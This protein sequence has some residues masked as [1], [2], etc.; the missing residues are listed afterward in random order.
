[1]TLPDGEI[2]DIGT[3]FEVRVQE[4]VTRAVIVREGMVVLKLRNAAP[5]AL[6]AGQSWE[7]PS[8]E[9]SATPVA[10]TSSAPP[11][12]PT[13]PTTL[14]RA[15]APLS[16]TDVASGEFRDAVDTFNCG[17]ADDA[18]NRLRDFMSRHPGD[19]RTED[20][21]Y[22]RVIA[23]QRAGRSQDARDAARDYLQKYPSGFRRRE[24]EPV[25]R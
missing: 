25:A 8:A 10:I 14:P 5:V 22:L 20:A 6:A 21:A 16:P 19:S 15:R 24:I 3:V 2:Q 4:H 13:A 12:P 23:L 17:R 7:A 1:V 18:A 11:G 9:L